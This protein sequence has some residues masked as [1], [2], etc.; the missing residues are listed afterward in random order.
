MKQMTRVVT[1]KVSVPVTAVVSWV[2]VFFS[3]GYLLPWAIAATRGKSNHWTIF[4]INLLFGWTIVGWVIALILAFGQH[5]SLG[6]V[7]EDDPTW[8]PRY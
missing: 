7:V 1:D 4:W 6:F 8:A 5:K 2:L 3:Y